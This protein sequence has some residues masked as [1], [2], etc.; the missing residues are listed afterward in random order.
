MA[1]GAS[2]K[3]PLGKV[4]NGVYSYLGSSV[5]KASAE[6]PYLATYSTTDQKWSVV[7]ETAVPLAALCVVPK[8]RKQTKRLLASAP[9]RS[10]LE[11][12]FSA[13]ALL[14]GSFAKHSLFKSKTDALIDAFVA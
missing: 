13:H 3:F 9:E 11:G 4:V 2:F 8:S 1:K 5:Y 12:D 7:I 10:G 14:G 6:E